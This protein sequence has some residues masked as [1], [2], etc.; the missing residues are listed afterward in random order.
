ML[1][2]SCPL[3]HLPFV[4]FLSLLLTSCQSARPVSQHGNPRLSDVPQTTAWLLMTAPG[5]LPAVVTA[6]E[7][8]TLRD[9]GWWRA[10]DGTISARVRKSFWSTLRQHESGGVLLIEGQPGQQVQLDIRNDS[11]RRIE[12]VIDWN[13]ADPSGQT[14]F[15]KDRSGVILDPGE[16]KTLKPLTLGN[17]ADANAMLR[18]EPALQNGVARLSVFNSAGKPPAIFRSTAGRDPRSTPYQT[19]HPARDYEYR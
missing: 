3:S 1:L 18:H 12:V 5:G 10:G 7:D 6:R 15:P 17:V 4:A 9:R 8:V 11:S 14:G 2:T 13:G 19:S 16:M